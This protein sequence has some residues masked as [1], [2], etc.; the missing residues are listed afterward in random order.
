MFLF[1]ELKGVYF[2]FWKFGN[3]CDFSYGKFGIF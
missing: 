2:I 3:F 1:E